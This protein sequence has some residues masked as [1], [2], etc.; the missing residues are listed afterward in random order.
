M[1]GYYPALS[2]GH[3][4]YLSLS[5]LRRRLAYGESPVEGLLHRV[6]QHFLQHPDIGFAGR[7]HLVEE[8]PGPSCLSPPEVALT[9]LGLHNFAAAS[10]VEAALGT[11]MSF[12]LR[13]LRL[14]DYFLFFG[15][16]RGEQHTHA[17]ALHLGRHLYI[18]FIFKGPYNPL[19]DSPGD[20][21]VSHLPP[22]ENH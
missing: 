18:S 22:P 10:N 15:G 20:V 1:T 9:A 3:F 14:R 16:R 7:M 17:S 8:S 5:C 11:F 6:W 4:Y 2:S 19:Q 12:E 21:R 13:H